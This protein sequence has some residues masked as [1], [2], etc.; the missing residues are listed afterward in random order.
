MG[1]GSA[2]GIPTFPAG[3]MRHRVSL[4]S[5]IQAP[6]SCTAAALKRV[7]LQKLWKILPSPPRAST[8]FLAK[9]TSLQLQGH[10][11]ASPSPSMSPGTRAHIVCREVDSARNL[12]LAPGGERGWES[13]EHFSKLLQHKV[14]G[15]G[16][17]GRDIGC[18]GNV[19]YTGRHMGALLVSAS[20]GFCLPPPTEK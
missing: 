11:L 1:D 16:Q 20:A 7:V 12:A 10:S 19:Q 14:P 8:E 6:R 4:P 17:T 2:R 3:S 5:P 18:I 15:L 13:C 9:A